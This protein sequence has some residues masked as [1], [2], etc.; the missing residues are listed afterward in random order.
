MRDVWSTNID[1]DG[2]E[3]Y[4]EIED[5][6][7]WDVPDRFNFGTDVVDRWARERDGLALIWENHAGEERRYTYSEI[8][9]LTNRFG[10]LLRAHGVK[11][12]DRVL[13]IL[14]RI[15]EWMIV[16]VGALKIGAVAIPGIE[17]LTSKDIAYRVRNSGARAVVCRTS[18]VEK[19]ADLIDEIPVRIAIGG[20][21]DWVDFDAEM[22]SASIDLRPEPVEREDPAVMYYTSGSTGY[23]KGVLHASRGLYAWRVSAIHW[24]D[25][26]PG[27]R[28]WCT[29]DTGWSKA[30][31]SVLFGPWSCGACTFLY[32][33]PFDPK[34]RLRLLQKHR[35]TVYCAPGTELFRIVNEDIGGYDLSAL[36]RTI[37]GGESVSPGLAERWETATGTRIDEGYGL[38]ESLIVVINIPGEP[39][40][41]GS[42]GRPGPGVR[43]EVVDETGT[44]LPPHREGDIAVLTPNPQMMLGYWNDEERTRSCFRDSPSG[45]WFITGDRAER[46]EDGYLWFRGRSDDVINS[47][48]YRIGPLEVENALLEHPAVISCAVIGSPD[49]ERGEIVKAFVVLKEGYEPGDALSRALQEHVKSVTAPYKYPRAIEYLDALPQTITGKISRK[50]LRLRERAAADG[51]RQAGLAGQPAGDDQ[52]RVRA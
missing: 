46:D 41:Y 42:M 47:A 19:F 29:A 18:Q 39:V 17:M 7:R 22:D 30:G 1:L 52:G 10:N 37:S 4:Q 26:R 13:V 14:P 15:P 16:M 9:A 12:G 44:P 31:T 8:A 35:I 51:A 27:E 3:S 38:T 11:K 34:H 25:L 2:T 23:P 40:K 21:P 24:L 5:A 48:G 50:E 43:V 33:G 6:F 36:R 20:A 49:L 32:D 45:R 28:I